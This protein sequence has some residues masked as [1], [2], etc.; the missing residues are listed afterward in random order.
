VV[1]VPFPRVRLLRLLHGTPLLVLT[2][3]A[4]VPA[5]AQQISRARSDGDLLLLNGRFEV[6]L[7]A[8]DP[9]TGLTTTGTAHAL[10]DG[11][12]YF[13]LPDFTNSPTFPE[14]TLKMVDA[15]AAAPPFGGAFWFFYSSLTDV[16]YTLTVTDRQSGLVRTYGNSGSTPFCGGADTNAFPP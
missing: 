14:I 13:S 16:D 1:P 7:A 9:R 15:T 4:A 11:S 3:A 12:G 5:A 6:N 10:S 2:L 8:T